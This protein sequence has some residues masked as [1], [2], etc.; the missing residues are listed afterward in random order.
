M[1][2]EAAMSLDQLLALVAIGST[3][4]SL[5]KQ[6]QGR[7]LG[8]AYY[9]PE[10]KLWL[11]ADGLPPLRVAK[12]RDALAASRGWLMVGAVSGFLSLYLQY[13]ASP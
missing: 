13:G 2:R 8:Q 5:A 1:G 4:W 12:A 9:D 11:H 3:L 7:A 10:V 6:R